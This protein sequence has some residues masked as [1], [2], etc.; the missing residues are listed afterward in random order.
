MIAPLIKGGKLLEYGA[1]LVPEGGLGMMPPL[2]MDGLLLVGDAAGLGVNNGFSVR[3]MDLAIGSAVAAA[4]TVIDAAAAGDF[5]YSRLSGYTSRLEQSFVM[6]DMRT[7]RR[8]VDF[9]NSERL[10][11]AYPGLL[12]DIFTDIYRQEA[13]PKKNL[14]PTLMQNIKQSQVSFFDLLRDVLAGGRAL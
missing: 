6:Q 4:D 12:A 5:G 13:R 14:V 7:Y 2:V 3:G 11:E 9:M 8:A 10:F 1:H